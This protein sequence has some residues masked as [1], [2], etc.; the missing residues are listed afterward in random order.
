MVGTNLLKKK[1]QTTENV[2]NPFPPIHTLRYIIGLL[3]GQY[4]EQKRKDR[5]LLLQEGRGRGGFLTTVNYMLENIC[6]QKSS[7]FPQGNNSWTEPT[8]YLHRVG[9]Y[10]PNENVGDRKKQLTRREVI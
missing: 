3:V 2:K 4:N 10:G 9:S 5:I 8:F 7:L 1:P 6:S